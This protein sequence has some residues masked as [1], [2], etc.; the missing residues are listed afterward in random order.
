MN[1][2]NQFKCESERARRLSV[3]LLLVSLLSWVAWVGVASN[4][5]SQVQPIGWVVFFGAPIATYLVLLAAVLISHKAS[6]EVRYLVSVSLMW[7][8]MVAA[9]GYIAGWENN[10][11]F[12]RYLTLFV[13]PPIGIWFGFA[14]WKWSKN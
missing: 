13:L 14:L 8:F 11:S 4:G 3:S 5:F 2:I 7:F 12:E 10:L 1:Q 9:W 6:R